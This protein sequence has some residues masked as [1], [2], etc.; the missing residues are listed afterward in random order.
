MVG[1]LLLGWAV[2]APLF[3]GVALGA[4]CSQ[5]WLMFQRDQQRTGGCGPAPD[6][7]FGRVLWTFDVE[8]LEVWGAPVPVGDT[9]YATDSHGIVYAVD[10]REGTLR[11][12]VSTGGVRIFVSPVVADGRAFVGTDDGAL[13]ALETTQGDMVWRAEFGDTIYSPLVAD[14]VLYFTSGHDRLHAVDVTS[15]TE[16][17]SVPAAVWSATPVEVDGVVYAAGRLGTLFG[18]QASDG[19]IVL[20]AEIPHGVP[21]GLATDG[22]R[23]FSVTAAGEAFAV[24]REG[25]ELLWSRRVGRTVSASPVLVDDILYI[26]SLRDQVAALDATSGE[27]MW[28]TTLVGGMD[29][30]P[31]PVNGTLYVPTGDGR[32]HA[33]DRMTGSKSWTLRYGSLSTS[34]ITRMDDTLFVAASGL[35]HGTVVAIK[36]TSQPDAPSSDPMDPGTAGEF[37]SWVTGGVVLGLVLVAIV[38]VLVA[39]SR[40]SRQGPRR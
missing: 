24:D 32:I 37:W 22:D 7:A 35:R 6:P 26:A 8:A 2:L 21:R 38:T 17:W 14:G 13:V 39:C 25:G 4:N 10:A 27:I 3:S 18:F 5:E 28:R 23:L 1:T 11:W 15:G 30:T 33:V 16:R 12:S 20:R 19:A 31:A 9:V 36:L 29:Q 40:R 34:P